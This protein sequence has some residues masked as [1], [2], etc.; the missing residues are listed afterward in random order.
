M[1]EPIVST[2]ADYATAGKLKGVRVPKNPNAKAYFAVAAGTLATADRFSTVA[3][4]S[5][6][7]GLACDTLG[8]GAR[9]QEILVAGTAGTGKGICTFNCPNTQTA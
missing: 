1:S 9:I 8:L 3:F 7:L 2:D 4:H 5:D 6:S